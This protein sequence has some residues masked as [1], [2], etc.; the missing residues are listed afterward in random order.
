MGSLSQVLRWRREPRPGASLY[1][2]RTT[3]PRRQRHELKEEDSNRG[4]KTPRRKKCGLGNVQQ[5]QCPSWR[6]S[7]QPRLEGS[8]RMG[9]AEGL[10]GPKVGVCVDGV[11]VCPGCLMATSWKRY[12]VDCVCVCVR[13]LPENRRLPGV[14]FL[15]RWK[16]WGPDMG[17]DFSS[18][19][20]QG[21]Y[22]F[23]HLVDL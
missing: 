19:G 15:R 6:E 13:G 3:L 2:V 16:A 7:R 21:C 14:I 5:S 23:W 22:H 10:L 4:S 17:Q 20:A 1:L 12:Q 18:S 11:R 9:P 8:L